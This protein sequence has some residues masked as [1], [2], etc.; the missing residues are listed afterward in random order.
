[1]G[2]RIF[3]ISN[4]LQPVEISGPQMN[5]SNSP[6]MAKVGDYL[7]VGGTMVYDVRDPAQPTIA[8]MVA[9]VMGAWDCD[10]VGDRVYIVTQMQGL[11]V[12]RFKPLS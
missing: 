6:G 10:V 9:D 8:G 1:M 5:F 2:I 3:D 7:F 4:P 12:Y 11:Y